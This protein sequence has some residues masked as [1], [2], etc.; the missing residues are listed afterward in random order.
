MIMMM[1]AFFFFLGTLLARRNS[2]PCGGAGCLMPTWL[3]LYAP[4]DLPSAT[5][6]STTALKLYASCVSVIRSLPTRLCQHS[7]WYGVRIGMGDLNC[8]VRWQCVIFL[9]VKS[10]ASFSL[11]RRSSMVRLYHI[12]ASIFSHFTG[13]LGYYETSAKNNV[14][15]DQVISDLVRMHRQR[16]SYGLGWSQAATAQTK[17]SLFSSLLPWRKSKKSDGYVC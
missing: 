11:P 9:P 13:F 15:I 17:P 1:I 7:S 16:I 14:N 10:N 2:A 8:N 4:C 12:N 6:L 5:M 3:C